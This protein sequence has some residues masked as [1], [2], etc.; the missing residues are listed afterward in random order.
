MNQQEAQDIL[1][2]LYADASFREEFFADRNSFYA[3]NSITDPE[4]HTFLDE[5]KKE[6]VDFF[7]KSLLAK[8]RHAVFGLLPG[9]FFLLGQNAAERFNEF[10]Q[11]FLPSGIHKHHADAIA[12]CSYLLKQENVSAALNDQIRFEQKQLENFISGKRW[13]LLRCRHNVVGFQRDLLAGKKDVQPEKR[14]T[15]IIWRKGRIIRVFGS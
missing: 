1:S 11:T 9:T 10:A 3:S 12:F 13:S 5:L 6:Q 14:S 15:T 7:A 8:R 2:R 4:L